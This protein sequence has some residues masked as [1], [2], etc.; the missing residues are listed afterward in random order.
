MGLFNVSKFDYIRRHQKTSFTGIHCKVIDYLKDIIPIEAEREFAPYSADVYLPTLN[1]IIECDGGKWHNYPY[2]SSRDKHRDKIIKAKYKVK[3]IYRIW[4]KDIENTNKLKLI[5]DGI[6][7]GDLI[8]KLKKTQ[9]VVFELGEKNIKAKVIK[10]NK[11]TFKAFVPQLKTNITIDR[12]GIAKI[13]DSYCRCVILTNSKLI[14]IYAN[15]LFH[16]FNEKAK[17]LNMNSVKNLYK[18]IKKRILSEK[19]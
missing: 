7:K 17:D 6:I 11:F 1:S 10:I 16:L 18:K 2:G 5:L 3:N 13:H 12:Y 15:S 4:G 19:E 8:P 14:S 9:D